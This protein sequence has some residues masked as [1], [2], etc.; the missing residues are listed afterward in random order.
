[1][2]LKYIRRNNSKADDSAD[3]ACQV[4]AGERE[5]DEEIK[6]E[7]SDDTVTRAYCGD[8]ETLSLLLNQTART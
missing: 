4:N 3:C 8:V 2:R 1:V 5:G 6:D 7:E